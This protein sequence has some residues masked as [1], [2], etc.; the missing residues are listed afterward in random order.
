MSDPEDNP[1]DFSARRGCVWVPTLV[2][3]LVILITALVVI[4]QY[5]FPFG[6]SQAP[7]T[8]APMFSPA[9]STSPA[10]RDNA[11]SSARNLSHYSRVRMNAIAKIDAI[12]VR[13]QNI[14]MI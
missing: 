7:S 12:T 3:A 6:R 5:R 4:A 8:N 13:L 11:G 2:A 14:C 9:P 10:S 1:R